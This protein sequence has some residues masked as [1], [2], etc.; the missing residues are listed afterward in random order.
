MS[1]ML[2]YG[3][4]KKMKYVLSEYLSIEKTRA[5]KADVIAE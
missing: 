3:K 4:R 5:K 2:N 1:F